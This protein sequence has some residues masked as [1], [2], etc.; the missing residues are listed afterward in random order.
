MRV[1]IAQVVDIAILSYPDLRDLLLL[2][3]LVGIKFCRA[4]IGL[5]AWAY[6]VGHDHRS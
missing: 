6:D 3:F 4:M 5:G 2:P 1:P